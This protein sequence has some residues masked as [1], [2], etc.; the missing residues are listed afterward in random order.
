MGLAA[1]R[2]PSSAIKHYRQEPVAVVEKAFE[3][4]GLAS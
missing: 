1:N 4:L 3:D 2:L